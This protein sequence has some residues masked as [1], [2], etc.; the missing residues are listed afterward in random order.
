MKSHRLCALFT[1]HDNNFAPFNVGVISPP[2]FS[3]VV[4]FAR[5]SPI[6]VVLIWRSAA[7]IRLSRLVI[8]LFVFCAHSW[9]NWSSFPVYFF[10][11][12]HV[13]WPFVFF[14]FVAPEGSLLRV[15]YLFLAMVVRNLQEWHRGILRSAGRPMGPLKDTIVFPLAFSSPPSTFGRSCCPVCPFCID[16]AYF[17]GIPFPTRLPIVFCVR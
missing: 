5:I 15:A 13:F 2:G 11:S 4:R 3:K 16:M 8:C 1:H 10:V 14:E 7:D 12:P 6:V 9:K 17:H